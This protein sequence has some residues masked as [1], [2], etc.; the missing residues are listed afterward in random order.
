MIEQIPFAT[1]L[2]GSTVAALYDL[3]TTEIPDKI[4]Y[5]MIAI[6]L[7]F[8]GY[9]SYSLWDYHLLLNS[10]IAGLGLLTF[11]FLMYYTGQWG[12]GDAKLLAAIGF[13]IP[14]TPQMFPQLFFPFPL[15]YLINLFLVGALYMIIYA[16]A[17]AILNRKIIT[18]FSKDVKA[19]SKVIVMGSAILFVLF[20]AI[21]SFLIKYL[22]LTFDFSMVFTNSLVPLLATIGLFVIWKFAKTVE[23][24]GFRKKIPVSK[25]KV[26]DVLNK[27]K[28]WE[29]ITEKELKLIK[30]SGKKF[31]VV[32]EGIR[33][34]AAFPLALLFTLYYGDGILLFLRFLV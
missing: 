1:V 17:L 29:G 16:F 23:N 14:Q 13:L 20:F 18:S 32:K 22:Q 12:G 4:P 28:L 31:I 10:L 21:N 15:S 30:K 27:S 6:G 33:F 25:L 5:I 7:L 8:F 19:S 24:V 3:K 11:G 2:I 9:E 26:G 34:A